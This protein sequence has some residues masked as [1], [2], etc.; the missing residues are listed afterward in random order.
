M[1]EQL[2]IPVEHWFKDVKKV[3]ALKKFLDDKDVQTAFATL[4]KSAAPSHGS[5]ATD[6]HSNSTRLAYYAGYCD[7][8]DD[9]YKLT[10]LKGDKPITQPEEWNH[11]QPNHP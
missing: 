3:H 2:P 9:L 11:I 10:V 8:C 1:A 5:L 4:R 7:F 6:P